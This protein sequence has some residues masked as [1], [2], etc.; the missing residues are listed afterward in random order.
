MECAKGSLHIVEIEECRFCNKSRMRIVLKILI[1]LHI[2][3]AVDQLCFLF[4]DLDIPTADKSDF[5]FEFHVVVSL[6]V[7]T[8]LSVLAGDGYESNISLRDFNGRF[9]DSQYFPNL[10]SYAI[11]RK[12][13][14]SL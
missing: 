13:R 8:V 2:R 10:K 4:L 5:T 11:K 3:K 7:D 12:H 1:A 9:F 14:L 6:I